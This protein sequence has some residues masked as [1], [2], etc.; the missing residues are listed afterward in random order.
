MTMQKQGKH[1]LTAYTIL[2][3]RPRAVKTRADVSLRK[4][5]LVTNKTTFAAYVVHIS[6]SNAILQMLF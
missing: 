5:P 3:I 6:D 2:Q 4:E 1:V